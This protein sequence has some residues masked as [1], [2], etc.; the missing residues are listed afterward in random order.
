MSDLLLPTVAA[1]PAEPARP[2]AVAAPG[3]SEILAEL[4]AGLAAGDDLRQLLDRFLQPI[5]QIAGAQAGAV[6]IVDP[7]EHRMLLVGQRGLP[8]DLRDAE[9]SVAHDCGVCGV[10]LADDRLAWS[11]GLTRCARRSE[12]RLQA[13]GM[14]QVLAVPLGHRGRVLGLFNLFFDAGQEPPG[15]VLALLKSIGDLLGL[16]LDNARLEREHLR[17][18]VLA[19]RQAMAADLHDSMG[20]LLTFAKMRLPLL[21][22]AIR[23]CDQDSAQRYFDDVRSAIG[24]AHTS[25][26][27]ILTQAR[28][29]MD[30]L[31]LAHAL[32]GCVETFRRRTGVPLD[33]VD[34]AG[35]LQLSAEQDAQVFHVVQE[36]LTNVA[37]H[38]RAQHAWLRIRP[39]AGGRLQVVVEDD[40]AGVPPA[41]DAEGAQ[42]THYGLSIMRER[43]QRLGGALEVGPRAGGGTRV[44]LEFD[45]HKPAQEAP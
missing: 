37:R 31:G 1:A 29:P 39:L 41:A 6:R 43:A 5:V 35:G 33:F 10:A 12:L 40:G 44:R 7:H 36:A 32:Q 14:R 15:H 19:E 22:D 27:G 38:A 3:V 25:L 42:G 21:Q 2:V 8:D 45:L 26:R 9:R 24:Q 11:D 20:Q 34:E 23:H 13:S 18:T 30:P 4:T 16:A 17:A 28:T